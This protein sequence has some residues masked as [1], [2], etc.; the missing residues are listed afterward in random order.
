[1][2][3]V[4]ALDLKD[5]A[6]LIAAYEARHRAVWPEVLEHLRRHGVLG[7]QIWRLG[8]RMVM[9]M[10]T[11]DA[12]Y[13]SQRMR[14]DTENDPVIRKWEELMWTFQAPTPWTP[15]GQKWAPM[16]CVFDVDL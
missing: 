1:M 8:T 2:R 11:D 9:V 7:M 6:E 3:H 5:D 4:L 16:T 15:K 12:I 10:S 14:V 13:D